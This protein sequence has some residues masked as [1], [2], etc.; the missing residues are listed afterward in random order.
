MA[1]L[2]SPSVGCTVVWCLYSDGTDEMMTVEAYEAM[3]EE[4]DNAAAYERAREALK[5]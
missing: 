3:V 5:G 2:V 4:N 1:T